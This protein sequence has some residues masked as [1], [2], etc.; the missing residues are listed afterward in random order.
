[1]YI[2]TLK[3]V[4]SVH[5]KEYRRPCIHERRWSGWEDLNFRPPSSPHP[6]TAAAGRTSTSGRATRLRYTPTETKTL[7]NFLP[8][9]L[10]EAQSRNRILMRLFWSDRTIDPYSYRGSYLLSPICVKYH[11]CNCISL[12]GSEWD[13]VVPQR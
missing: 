7:R 10:R 9:L 13:R 3:Y 4:V 11:R 12:P 6:I 5:K 8:D 2:S 1:M